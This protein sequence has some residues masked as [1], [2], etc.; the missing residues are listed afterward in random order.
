M[1]G[2]IL[3]RGSGGSGELKTIDEQYVATSGQ[4]VFPI[5][6]ETFD[7]KKDTV[8]VTS[9]RTTLTQGLDYAVT[10]N[11]IKLLEGVPKG[12]TV[13]IRIM[14]NVNTDAKDETMSGVYIEK[15]TLP[16]DRLAEQID[17]SGMLPLDGSKAMTANELKLDN[18][19]GS[20]RSDEHCSRLITKDKRNNDSSMRYIEVLNPST[21]SEEECV[22]LVTVGDPEYGDLS[23]C[24]F[25]EHNLDHM[26]EQ[27]FE[28][29]TTDITAGSSYLET[30]KFY[31]VYE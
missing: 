6:Y 11:S 24:I 25:G 9:G 2:M 14:K 26:R 21:S 13:T 16:L 17:L 5:A 19:Y 29:S 31:L 8:F 30:N 10:V 7:Y 12:R 28:K 18:G 22:Q 27:L 23:R 15:G 3:K 1:D 4:T 20:I